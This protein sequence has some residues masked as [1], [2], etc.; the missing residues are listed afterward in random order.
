MTQAPSAFQS[1]DTVTWTDETHPLVLLAMED[2]GIERGAVGTVVSA[3]GDEVRVRFPGIDE[4]LE[5]QQSD[6]QL[7]SQVLPQKCPELSQSHRQLLTSLWTPRK[8]T[9][10]KCRCH[11]HLNL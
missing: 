4:V 2:W 10:F 5:L 6:S 9:R 7:A 8:R 1:G 11:L 3:S